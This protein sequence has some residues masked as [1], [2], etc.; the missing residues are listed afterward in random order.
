MPAP[1]PI[2]AGTVFS[3]L[4]VL[5]PD[6]SE[7]GYYVCRCECGAEKSLRGTNLRCGAI[8]SCGCLSR[9]LARERIPK[10]SAFNTK[11]GLHKSR[12]YMAWNGMR[13]RCRNPNHRYF[14]HYGGR[15]IYV[16]DRWQSF[17]NFFADM[18][19]PPPNHTLERRDNDGPYSPDNCYWATRQ[20]Q[21]NNRRANR[22][23]TAFGATR[24]IA[25]WSRLTGIHHNTLTKRI[26]IGMAPE[27]ALSRTPGPQRIR[28]MTHCRRGHPFDEAN[29]HY[30]RGQRVCRA[31]AREK[32]TQERR[33][34]GIPPRHP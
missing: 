4:T 3:R 10:L 15:G 2:A 31:C 9:E 21:S 29:T 17:E 20:E 19:H 32:A 30:Y 13:D 8:R 26:E 11:H 14:S 6:P 18:G 7:P 23:I 12:A 25:E 22:R 16:C 27:A 24:T 1:K 28:Q 33:A 34:R 5:R